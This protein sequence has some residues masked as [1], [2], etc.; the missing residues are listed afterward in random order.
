MSK[1]DKIE[2]FAPTTSAELE[3]STANDRQPIQQRPPIAE[4]PASAPAARAD[5]AVMQPAPI[6][7]E[8][9]PR[10][11]LTLRTLSMAGGIA[12]VAVASAVAWLH[13]GRY[14]STDDA[15]V[16]AAKLM[17]STDVSGIVT[18][19]E[20]HEGQLVKAGDVL[21]CVDPRQFQIALDNAK[22]NLAQAALTIE[23]M[24]QDYKRMLSDIAA[25]QAQVALDQATFDRYAALV[26]SDSISKAKYDKAHFTLA[27][28]QG[29]LESL[30]ILGPT[31]GGYLTDVY[32]WR[33]VFYIN[34]PF[35]ILA[36]AGIWLFLKDTDRDA[37]LQFDWTG[38]AALSVGLGALQ[39]ML[40]RGEQKDW[41]G[42]T[43]IVVYAVL[44]GLGCYLF[45]VHLF[46]AKKPFIA[47]RMFRDMNFVSGL[48]MM[49][50]VGMVLLASSALLAPYL[51][52]L[53]GY[54]VSEAGLLMAPRGAGTMVAMLLAGRLSNRVDPRLL[55]LAGIL[56]LAASM[57]EMTGWTPDIDAWR[58]SAA[59]I[60]QGAGLG[61]VFTP[62]QVVA[63]ASL[64]AELRTDGTALFSLVRNV[65]SAIGISITSFLLVHN[66]QIMHAQIAE[67]VTPFNRMLQTGGAYLMWNTATSQGLAALNAEVTRQ[68]SIIAYANDFKL[69]FFVC[70]PTALLLPLMRRP[71]THVQ[72]GGL[73]VAIH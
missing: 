25:E 60:V 1:I 10:R 30:P 16:G 12:I 27:A 53:A 29:K 65:G 52:N 2:T 41:F 20:V 8:V 64:P 28:D 36:F 31:L 33:W 57:W 7:P 39:L 56:L 59:S 46:T 37:R 54:S 58:M 19:V 9:A 51:Q 63:F 49:F 67:S 18:S 71:E 48:L 21:F 15:Y 42:S 24:K 23:A 62:L 66:T 4:A 13:G 40:D 50:A 14:A 68:A 55:M 61:L 70:L 11:R 6:V 17:V 5:S 47:P 73:R 69:M 34:L 44:C 32:E 26:R 43:E 38:F 72:N 22:A 45:L 3:P 35:G